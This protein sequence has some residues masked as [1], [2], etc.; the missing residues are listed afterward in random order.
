MPKTENRKPETDLSGREYLGLKSITGPLLVVTGVRGVG[1]DES[2]EV[3]A[4]DGSRQTGR[5][6]AVGQ[7][8]AVIELFGETVGL[9][10]QKTR[11]RFTGSPLTAPVSTDLLGR[12]FNGMGQPLD[13][14]PLP[15]GEASRDINGQPI[16]P[17][18]RTYPQEFIQTGISAID[19]MN[20]LVRGQKLPIFAMSGLPHNELAAQIVRQARLLGEEGRFAIVF[21]A[22]GVQHDVANIFR[23]SFEASGVLNNV[24]MFLN[25]A[26]DPAIE[27]L[28]TPRLA[29]TVAEFLAFDRDH[30]VLA[31]LTDMTNYCEALREVA[32][33][34]GE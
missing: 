11:V 27:R 19:G 1:F 26:S 33:S 4:P 5:V 31:I 30:H 3:T 9:S 25:L 10:L 16:N 14:G 2:V 22:M 29:L 32:S 6:L 20:T 8:E 21:A 34:K 23:Q 12:I 24:V 13:G 28:V 15:V 7:D 18:A 17:T